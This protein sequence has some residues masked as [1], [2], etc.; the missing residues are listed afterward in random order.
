MRLSRR[1]SVSCSQRTP[2]GTDWLK[3]STMGPNLQYQFRDRT[4]PLCRAA[5]TPCARPSEVEVQAYL[6][7]PLAHAAAIM[8]KVLI[9]RRYAVSR[10]ARRG[11]PH[12]A[13]VT[14]WV[15]L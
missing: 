5:A 9:I 14:I 15:G 2:C 12:L 10:S 8:I 7:T 11:H 1:V 13:R 3:R 6:D 4:H